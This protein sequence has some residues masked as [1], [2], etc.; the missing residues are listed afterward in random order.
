MI[1]MQRPEGDPY[2]DW[3][4]SHRVRA[5]DGDGEEKSLGWLRVS[6]G[7]VVCENE[8]EL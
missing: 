1:G 5:C 3:T 6:K 7:Q 4:L 2:E 8:G